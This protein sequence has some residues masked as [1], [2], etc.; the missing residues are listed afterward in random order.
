MVRPQRDIQA[1]VLELLRNLKGIEP[2]KQLFW[3]QLNY[4]RVNQ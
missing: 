2:L 1:A 3:S 4:S